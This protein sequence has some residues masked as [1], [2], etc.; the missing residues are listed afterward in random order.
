MPDGTM[1]HMPA[2]PGSSRSSVILRLLG[3]V[4]KNWLQWGKAQARYQ[5]V[6]ACITGVLSGGDSSSASA[7]FAS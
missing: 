7:R 4:G 5:G 6:V 2:I 3:H 1:E